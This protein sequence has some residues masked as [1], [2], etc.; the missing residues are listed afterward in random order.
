LA[1]VLPCWLFFGQHFARLGQ[2]TCE[3]GFTSLLGCSSVFLCVSWHL[4]FSGTVL[5][6]QWCVVKALVKEGSYLG[7]QKKE[8]PKLVRAGDVLVRVE[9]AGI[10]RTDIYAALGKIPT[11]DP[12]ILGHE[13]SGVV[14]ELGSEVEGLSCGDRVVVNPLIACGQ[15][16]FCLGGE[17][18][19]C[20]ESK[21]L[22]IDYHGAF[23]GYVI[24]P[25]GSLLVITSQLSSLAAAYCEPVAASLAVLKS[26]IRPGEK[27]IIF[28]R[29]RFSQL[30]NKILKLYGFPELEVVGAQEQ[31]RANYYDYVIETFVSSAVLVD[32]CRAVRPGGKVLLKSRQFEPVSFRL[33]DILKKEP[34]FHVL[35][36][37]SFTD[38]LD[39]LISG[40]LCVDDL[41]DDIYSL[42]E[43]ERVFKY[44]QSSESLKPFFNPW[45]N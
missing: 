22:G 26:G 10:C 37:G 6:F 41:V 4:G 5:P 2:L 31:F 8:K 38:A 30:V 40:R 33:V 14:E 3:K 13:L 1:P 39:L 29:N 16:E 9:L 12:L 32:M 17:A 15:C 23:A 27:G 42:D 34:V 43:Y 45:L 11:I 35:N 19:I 44:S 18:H 7:L 21:F 24:C 20:Q 28:G 36:Y 25:A